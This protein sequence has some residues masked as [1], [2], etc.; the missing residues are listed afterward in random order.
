M[1]RI[2][3]QFSNSFPK[4]IIKMLYSGSSCLGNKSEVPV[5]NL[6]FNYETKSVRYLEVPRSHKIVSGLQNVKKK[7]RL[8]VDL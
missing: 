8:T 1:Y 4:Y 6:I 7:S 3:N 2:G 5:R